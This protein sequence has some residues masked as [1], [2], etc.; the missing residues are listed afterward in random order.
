MKNEYK[1]I[2]IGGEAGQGL[3]TLG[4]IMGKALVRSGYR[5]VVTQ[6]YMSRVRGGH[7]TFTLRVSP[8]PIEAPR[9]PIHLLVAMDGATPEINR[10]DLHSSGILMV[11]AEAEVEGKECLKVPFQELS[12]GEFKNV[13]A[14]GVITEILGLKQNVVTRIL[15]ESFGKHESV[16]A[17]NREALEAGFQ[18]GEKHA[19]GF[20]KLP[21]VTKSSKRLMMNGNEAIALGAAAAGL[22]FY[23][24]YP[25][26]P[27]TSIGNSLAK[28]ASKVGMVV[29]QG[30]DE[31]AVINMALGASFA[32]APSMVATSGGGFALMVEGVSL[33]AMTET[34]I[35]V[36]IG[37][38]PGPATGLPT[39]TEQ[40]D[41]EFVLHAGHGEFPRA[42]FAPGTIE[43]CFSLPQKALH[44]ADQFQTPVF[45]LTDQFLADSYRTVEPFSLEDV[46]PPVQPWKTRGPK[47]PAGYRRYEITENGISPRLLPGAGESL[48][49][50]DSDEHDETGHLTEDLLFRKKIAQKRL[51]K[52]E[53][54]LAGVIPPEYQ[55]DKNP[56]L[57]LVCWGSTRGSVAEAAEELRAKGKTAAMLHFSQVWPLIPG[58]FSR[59]LQ[60]AKKVVFVEGN[61]LGQFAR[62]I[63]REAGFGKAKAIR[64]YDG[65]PITPEY[66]LRNLPKR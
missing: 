59:T 37:Q 44:L 29:E 9:E 62:L 17:K 25:M 48:V 10:P 61:A 8:G 3:V 43:Q 14:L 55:G 27:S 57:L 19:G 40:G 30:E 28:W 64:R 52:G 32:G 7:N 63:R 34:P 18:W 24:F 41:L 2:M 56:D 33:A 51:R 4:D 23:S 36:V 21:A 49:V 1:N 60:K 65:L 31:I 45:L 53:G 11:D 16:M 12:P 20:L 58:Q 26:T 5:I 15:E 66:I 47:S 6:D 22:K 46:A 38:R 50:A 42:V 13:T 35:V 54:I 39:R